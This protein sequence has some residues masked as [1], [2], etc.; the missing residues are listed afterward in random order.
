MFIIDYLEMFKT[1]LYIIYSFQNLFHVSFQRPHIGGY[2]GKHMHENEYTTLLKRLEYLKCVC[3]VEIAEMLRFATELGDLHEN[4]EYDAAVDDYERVEREIYLL[5][6][7]LE[8]VEVIRK[9]ENN[10]IALGSTMVLDFDGL[11]ETYVIKNSSN[12]DLNSIFASSILERSLLG[13]GVGDTISI[14]SPDGEYI[15]QIKGI[16]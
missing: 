8:E 10:S 12:F 4:A 13:H 15:V 14:A 16:S 3:R 7:E 2:M 5:E 1:L 9:V 11:L 6:K